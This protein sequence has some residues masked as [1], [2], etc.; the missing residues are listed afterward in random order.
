MKNQ[1]KELLDNLARQ[2]EQLSFDVNTDNDEKQFE[3]GRISQVM[4]DHCA[5]KKILDGANNHAHSGQVQSHT[6][7]LNDNISHAHGVNNG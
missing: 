4:I 6:Q 1:L 2:L 3:R 5:I 7:Q